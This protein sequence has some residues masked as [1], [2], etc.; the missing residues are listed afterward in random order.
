MD[1]PLLSIIIVSYNTRELLRA[2]LVSVARE[3]TPYR[4]VIVVDNA[5]PDG[6][7]GMVEQEFPDVVLIRAPG[8]IGFSPAN[9]LGMSR[10]RG[11]H[12]LLLNPDTEIMPGGMDQWTA[13]H[14]R[15]G[16]VIS[17]TTLRGRDGRVQVSAWRAPDLLD[18]LLELFLMHHLFR[19]HAYPMGLF[20]ADLEVEALSGAAMLF[21]R[22]VVERYGGLDPEMFWMEDTD[23]CLRIREGGGTCWYLHGPGIVHVGGESAKRNLD[24]VISNQLISR[25]KFSRKHASRISAA[26]MVVV[27]GAHALSRALAFG[28]VSLFRQEPRASAYRHSLGR[29]YRYLFRGDRSI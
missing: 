10:A 21:H 1:R 28:M 24:R 26:F 19:R 22:D 7:A 16:A 2:C 6:S 17:G 5:S 20:G 29:L 15:T 8:N 12:L 18:A 23:L 4:E 14:Q 11:E 3:V 13:A 25:I 9:N 27:I